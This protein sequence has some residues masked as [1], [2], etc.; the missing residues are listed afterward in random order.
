MFFTKSLCFFLNCHSKSVLIVSC[1]SAGQVGMTFLA[2]VSPP[3]V[4]EGQS[5]KK[6][7]VQRVHC[8]WQQ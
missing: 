3:P 1:L 2:F 7:T 5:E 6:Y 4:L 8:Q